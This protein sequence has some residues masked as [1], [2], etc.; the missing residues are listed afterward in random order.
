MFYRSGPFHTKNW[1]T[2]IVDVGAET[3]QLLDVVEGRD[4]KAASRW[5]E[6]RPVEWRETIRYGALDLSGP[7]RRT[8]DDSLPH[9]A[10]V[11]DPFHL[12]RLAND[13]LD[14]VRRRVQNELVG[15]DKAQNWLS[16]RG[17]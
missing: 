17:P 10:Q 1:C 8:F 12:V 11:A 4:A 14:K 13:K 3:A 2:S 6:A 16:A 7:Y 15:Q 5:I 9:V